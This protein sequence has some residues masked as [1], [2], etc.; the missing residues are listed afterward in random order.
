MHHR[1]SITYSEEDSYIVRFD[2]RYIHCEPARADSL[3][4]WPFAR[5]VCACYVW[6]LKK[7]PTTLRSLPESSTP[8]TTIQNTPYTHTQT[9]ATVI[10]KTNVK[11]IHHGGRR[12]GSARAFA[13]EYH[14]PKVPSMGL[15]GREGRCR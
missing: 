14:R 13:Q 9:H 2:K 7:L 12:F 15:C 5:V 6:L 3:S 4:V 11:A 8:Y 10:Q 1:T